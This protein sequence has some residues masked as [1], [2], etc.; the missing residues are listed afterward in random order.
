MYNLCEFENSILDVYT[1]KRL[2]PPLNV[3]QHAEQQS[4]VYP[5]VKWIGYLQQSKRLSACLLLELAQ[6]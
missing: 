4:F 1:G 5:D 3:L 6:I 2:D